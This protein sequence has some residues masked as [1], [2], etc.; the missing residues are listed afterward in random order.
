[1]GKIAAKYREKSPKAMTPAE[2]KEWMKGA[3]ARMKA[4]GAVVLRAAINDPNDD[5]DEY[6]DNRVFYLVE[7][8][9]VMPG[10]HEWP[11][12]VFDLETEKGR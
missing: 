6:L 3:I 11:D 1:M 10:S 8:W 4:G 2:G 7:G 9:D 5:V 12:P